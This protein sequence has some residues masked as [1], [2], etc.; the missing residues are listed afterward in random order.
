MACF[1][2]KLK[3]GVRV[4]SLRITVFPTVKVVVTHQKNSWKVGLRR[5]KHVWQQSFKNKTQ[6]KEDV[7]LFEKSSAAQQAPTAQVFYFELSS[8]KPN[9][10]LRQQSHKLGVF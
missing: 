7:P 5:W 8:S 9:E 1:T 4:K 10:S 2:V 3:H 6:Y